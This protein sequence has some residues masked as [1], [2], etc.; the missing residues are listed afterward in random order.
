MH[1]D[2]HLRKLSQNLNFRF[3]NDESCIET[4]FEIQRNFLFLRLCPQCL[5]GHCLSILLE[6]VLISDG[7]EA[8]LIDGVLFNI[9]RRFSVALMGTLR[10]A[11]AASFTVESVLLGC[12]GFADGVTDEPEGLL[13]VLKRNVLDVVRVF[14]LVGNFAVTLR[15]VLRVVFVSSSEFR[16]GVSKF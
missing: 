8:V 1:S 3:D 12:I 6:P 2:V 16:V 10:R 9:T 13:V 4:K 15:D 11:V 5:H 7:L 14:G